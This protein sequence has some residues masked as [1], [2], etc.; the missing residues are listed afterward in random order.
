MPR[1]GT[2]YLCDCLGTL[3]GVLI[4]R[5]IFN[6]RG[7]GPLLKLGDASERFAAIL[8]RQ[9][10]GLD[11]AGL[12]QY[13]IDH[14]VEGIETLLDAAAAQQARLMVYKVIQHQL[15]PAK[16]LDILTQR[17]PDVLLLVRHRLDIW[18][19]II[20]ALA[21][22]KWHHRDTSAVEVAVNVEQ[23]LGWA[24]HSDGWYAEALALTEQHGLAVRVIDYDRDVAKPLT[25]LQRSARQM[26]DD[27]G[28]HLADGLGARM[29]IR[30]RQDAA[31][32]P[33]AKITNGEEVRAALAER[34]QLD[35]ALS[36]PLIAN[37][38]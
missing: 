21:V 18:I 16:L 1:T 37:P 9:I 32:D 2:S 4:A 19:S 5:E 27:L 25:E 3:P 10:E 13:F 20:K 17:R 29:P 36:S 23:F 31:T 8:G 35:Y 26:L 11:D 34:G 33:F 38:G 6:A 15:E 22:G 14:P 24:N 12:H 28:I 30:E 7:Y